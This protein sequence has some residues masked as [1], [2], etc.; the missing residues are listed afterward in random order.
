MEITLPQQGCNVYYGTYID[1][2]YNNT[3]TRY[4][5]NDG[6]LVASNSQSYNYNAIPTGAVCIDSLT[7]HSEYGVYFQFISLAVF[8]LAFYLI[9]RVIIKRL[10][11]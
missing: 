11:P 7:H 10:L 3:R 2:Y 6:M 4:Y 5:I 9:Y 8:A 1:N